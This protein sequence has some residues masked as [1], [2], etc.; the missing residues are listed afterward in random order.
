MPLRCHTIT[1]DR[2][3]TEQQHDRRK[4]IKFFFVGKCFIYA[5]SVLQ[6]HFKKVKT[7]VNV[8]PF[9]ATYC[10]IPKSCCYNSTVVKLRQNI[11]YCC[12]FL[13][14]FSYFSQFFYYIFFLFVSFLYIEFLGEIT[15]TGIGSEGEL[16]LSL[17]SPVCIYHN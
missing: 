7:T 15:A 5:H 8:N 14:F 17:S 4:E 3:N 1:K 13:F 16:F 6:R 9:L 10:K 2:L 11:G 12:C